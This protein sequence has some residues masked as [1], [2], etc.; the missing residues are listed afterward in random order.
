MCM[1]KILTI[2]TAR[3]GTLILQSM[4]IVHLCACASVCVHVRVCVTLCDSVDTHVHL[5]HV[6]CVYLCMWLFVVLSVRMHD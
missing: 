3:V 2:H 4:C 1:S 6:C 5:A